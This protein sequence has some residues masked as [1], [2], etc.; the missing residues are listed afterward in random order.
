INYSLDKLHSYFAE[1]RGSAK[2]TADKGGHT[3]QAGDTALD[4]C[5]DT[6]NLAL[7]LIPNCTFF[8]AG[9]SNWGITL[10]VWVKRYDFLANNSAAF[11]AESLSSPNFIGFTAHV[12]DSDDIVYFDVGGNVP[13][14]SELNSS[15][16]ILPAWTDDN[17]TNWHHFAFVKNGMA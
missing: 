6:G 4:F 11:W 14:D 16:T 13:G 15:I 2:L 7:P 5:V 10:S 17:W 8:N 1:I 12:P 9:A 3:R